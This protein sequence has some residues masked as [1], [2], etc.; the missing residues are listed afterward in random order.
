MKCRLPMNNMHD[1]TKQPS[2]RKW[3]ALMAA[4]VVLCALVAFLLIWR[5]AGISSAGA[6]SAA[7]LKRDKAINALLNSKSNIA[8]DA[9][10]ARPQNPPADSTAWRTILDNLTTLLKGGKVEVCGLSD[11]DAALFVAG[12]TETSARA[13]NT[14]LAQLIGKLLAEG[15]TEEQTQAL[16]LQALL[17]DWS[18]RI[19]DGGK[20][21]ICGADLECMA[22]LINANTPAGAIPDPTPAAEPLVRLALTSRDPN[23]IAAAIYACQGTRAGACGAISIADWAA[24]DAD[25]AAVWL[26]TA[27]DAVARKDTAARDHALRRAAIAPGYDL[28]VPSL[29]SIANSD[30]VEAQLP[31]VQFEIRN[32]LA[33]SN[34]APSIPQSLSVSSY[35]IHDERIH[36]DEVRRALC[37]TLANKLLQHDESLIGL[38]NAIAIGAKLGW[39]ASR[40][41]SLRDEKAVGLGW[42]YDAFPS[43]N[44][45]SCKQLAQ[46]NMLIQNALTKSER[47]IGRKVVANSGKSL[48]EVANEYRVS[49]PRLSK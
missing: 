7:V 47:Q 1:K 27:N 3:I 29:A 24:V 48:A 2:R 5:T 30:L 18:R 38:I 4:I 39:D 28:R 37:D 26:M 41:Q 44:M 31:I 23:I 6:T 10:M 14:T 15:K 22:K 16:Y 33:I 13:F 19:E 42:M 25:N 35:C 40:L 43:G 9:R 11:F 36:K 46:S 21:R 8:P 34:I 49:Y 45:F 17:P 12:D 32:Q 20:Y